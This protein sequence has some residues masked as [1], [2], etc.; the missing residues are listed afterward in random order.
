VDDPL[1]E[2]L[3]AHWRQAAG[4]ADALTRFAPVFGDLAGAPALV[5]ALAPHLRS[6]A[7]HGAAA[8]LQRLPP[9]A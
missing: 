6:L 1:S 2:A 4:D 7:E 8:T 9:A 3:S 5:A